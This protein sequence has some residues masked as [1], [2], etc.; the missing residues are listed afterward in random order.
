MAKNI[1]TTPIFSLF[2]TPARKRRKKKKV[3][4]FTRSK[5]SKSALKKAYKSG[6]TAG[7]EKGKNVATLSY[8]MRRK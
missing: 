2:A 5:V 1:F 3:N 6:Q 4:S 8:L 7:F